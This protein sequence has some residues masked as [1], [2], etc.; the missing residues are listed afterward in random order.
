MEEIR[1]ATGQAE[2]DSYGPENG[3]DDHFLP[4]QGKQI[5]M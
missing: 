3:A 4:M 5:V 1:I 2:P